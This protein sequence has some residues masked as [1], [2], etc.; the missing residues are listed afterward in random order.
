MKTVIVLLCI[1]LLLITGCIREISFEAEEAPRQ[2]VVYGKISNDPSPQELQIFHTGIFGTE[3]KQVPVE[4]AVATLMDDLGNVEQYEEQSPGVYWLQQ[5][6]VKGVPGRTYEL[7]IVLPGGKIIRSIP[8][9]MPQPVKAENFYLQKDT[10]SAAVIGYVDAQIPATADGQYLRWDTD[11]VYFFTE[12]D[13]FLL[14]GCTFCPLPLVCYVW[15]KLDRQQINLL[16][17]APGQALTLQRQE[18]VKRKVDRTFYHRNCFQTYQISMTKKAFEYWENVDKAANPSGTIFDSP[19]A[20]VRGN[21]YN[22]GDATELVLGYFEGVGVDTAR[23]CIS[24]DE[25]KP[26]QVLDPCL[27]NYTAN[28]LENYG[29]PPEC[30][31]CTLIPNSTL[32]KPWFW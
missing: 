10:T 16:S 26:I 1:M 27:R 32:E 23:A 5:S 13:Q 19:P 18:V 3:T 15:N 6:S 20:A 7:E 17:T 28:G 12:I 29:F 11:R 2:I 22:P 21:L 8:E 25:L 4:G 24:R 9:K 30:L 31:N 14:F